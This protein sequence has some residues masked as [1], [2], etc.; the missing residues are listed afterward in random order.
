MCAASAGKNPQW[1]FHLIPHKRLAVTKPHV[2]GCGKLRSTATDTTTKF[3]NRDLVHRSVRLAHAVKPTEF[4]FHHRF[5]IDRKI[6]DGLDI[7]MGDEE[8]W[9]CAPQHNN[10]N[11]IIF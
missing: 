4:I 9:I 11:C 5:P 7:E 8:L 6:K 3:S 10:S 1:N 2:A